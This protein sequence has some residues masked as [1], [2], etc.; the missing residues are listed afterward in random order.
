MR[1]STSINAWA[2]INNLF[3]KDPQEFLAAPFSSNFSTGTGLG[4][5]GDLRGRRYTVGVTVDF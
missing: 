5:T 2:V 4:V 1:G 3:D